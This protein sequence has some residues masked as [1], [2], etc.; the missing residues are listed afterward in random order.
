MIGTNEKDILNFPIY[1]I[2][3]FRYIM[4]S[5]KYF[6]LPQNEDKYYNR[7]F[8]GKITR[9]WNSSRTQLEILC[10]KAAKK[11]WVFVNVNLT[12]WVC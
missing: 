12:K 4:K 3:V 10:L 8:I 2:V 5:N 1:V 6:F 11:K 9:V 7:G